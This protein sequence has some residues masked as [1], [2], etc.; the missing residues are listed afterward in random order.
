MDG[1]HGSI[2]IESPNNESS[3]KSA[4]DGKQPSGAS[5]VMFFPAAAAN[6]LVGEPAHL[7]IS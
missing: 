1:H 5:F 3:Q 4:G 2:R 7:V 6:P